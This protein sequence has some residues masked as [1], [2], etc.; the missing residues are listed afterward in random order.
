MK[1]KIILGIVFLLLSVAVSVTAQQTAP[2]ATPAP[3]EAAKAPASA[4]ASSLTIA[5]ME[6][7]GS[8]MDRKPVDV[9]STFTASQDKV[10]CYL[11]FKDVMK[12][13]TVNVVWTLGQNEMG[14]AP[15]TIKPYAKFRTWASKSINGMKGDW[16]VDVV[17]DKGAVLQTASFKI[18]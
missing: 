18:Q 4:P 13:T 16:K 6:I 2:T 12:E 15:L 11:E 5:R 17:D 14:K 10:F 7:C 1:K 8:V 9:S 3:V